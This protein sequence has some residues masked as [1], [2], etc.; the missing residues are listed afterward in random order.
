MIPSSINVCVL[1]PLNKLYAAMILK[2]FLSFFV[3]VNFLFP[4]NFKQIQ[5]DTC[6]NKNNRGGT[7]FGS[8][9]A[10]CITKKR[11]A[12]SPP[13]NIMIPTIVIDDESIHVLNY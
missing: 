6:K 1:E 7:S 5:S 9:D 3:V 10:R 4:I 11:K 12:Y 2:N 13:Y 8:L